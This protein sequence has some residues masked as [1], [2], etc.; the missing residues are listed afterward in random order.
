MISHSWYPKV[1]DDSTVRGDQNRE[2]P[3]LRRGDVD[4]AVC[5]RDVPNIGEIPGQLESSDRRLRGMMY[6]NADSVTHV[7]VP[8]D[9]GRWGRRR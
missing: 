9:L 6:L 7:A 5:E 4:E 2:R 3:A 1:A 8:M